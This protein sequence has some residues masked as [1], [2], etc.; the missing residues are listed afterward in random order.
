MQG[1]KEER[2]WL[3]SPMRLRGA[4]VVLLV[5]CFV[6]VFFK[7]ITSLKILILLVKALLAKKY[8]ISVFSS[9]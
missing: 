7:I 9:T 6:V 1:Q 2:K 8:L 5:F 4:V 3:C